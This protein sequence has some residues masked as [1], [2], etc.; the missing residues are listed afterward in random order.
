MKHTTW[1]GLLGIMVLATAV[2]LGAGCSKKQEP[3]KAPVAAQ[4]AKPAA[5]APTPA[6]APAGDADCWGKEN[7]QAPKVEFEAAGIRY[8]VTG[9]FRAKALNIDATKPLVLGALTDI[10]SYIPQNAANLKAFF[11]EFR[12]AKVQAVLVAGDSGEKEDALKPVFEALAKEGFATFV[13]MGNRE[14]K[15]DYVKAMGEVQPQAKNL[16]NMNHVRVVDFGVATLLSVPG[17]YDANYIHNPPG[18]PYTPKQLEDV[19][20]LAAQAK[21]PVILL[22]HGPM[23]GQGPDAIDNAVEAGNVGDPALSTLINE[24]KIPF[25][26]FGNVHEAGGKA[27]GPDFKTVVK[28]DTPSAALY[29]HPGAADSDPWKL[30]DGSTS[31]GLAGILTISQ[32]KASYKIIKAPTPK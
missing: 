8:E 30:N 32:G 10:K 17:Y 23:R 25:G 26:V 20:A 13:V 31:R 12:K 16:V 15:A 28:Q 7:P 21:S 5:P 19:K 1:K 24:A 11:E 22:S 6:A 4:P 29:L 9:D 2:A 27:V 3:A 14:S 18:C